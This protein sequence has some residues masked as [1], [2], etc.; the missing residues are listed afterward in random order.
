[1]LPDAV[2][3][4][5]AMVW[6][7]SQADRVGLYVGAGLGGE[8]S[9]GTALGGGAR[10]TLALRLPPARIGEFESIVD[11]AVAV[12][13]SG[14]FDLIP[15]D[16]QMAGVDGFEATSRIRLHEQALGRRS[17]AI[18]ALTANALHGDRERSLAAGLNEHLAKPLDEA[19]LRAVLTRHL[20]GVPGAGAA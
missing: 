12:A 8:L 3:S 5:P 18:V 9:C 20:A 4:W 14:R 15:L 11:E 19:E 13:A 2:Q 17:V 7:L 10:F 16:C 6:Q 1:M